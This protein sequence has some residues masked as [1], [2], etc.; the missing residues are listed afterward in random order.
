MIFG[1]N[2]V[3][4]ID[5]GQNASG[6]PAVTVGY[7]RQEA[8]VMPLVANMDDDGAVQK[9][10]RVVDTLTAGVD[11]LHPC[12]LVG[13]KG[14]AVDT[15]SVLAS[16]GA[17]FAGDGTTGRATGGLAQFFSTGVAAQALALRGGAALVA[18][19][20]AAR[21]QDAAAAAVAPALTALMGSEE[22]KEEARLVPDRIEA[23][24]VAAFD[25]FRQLAD[26]EFITRFG[27]F[28]QH[29]A[30]PTAYCDGLD[31]NACMTKL[32]ADELFRSLSASEIKAAVDAAKAG[33]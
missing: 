33:A 1:T 20:D 29:L 28:S 17:Q 12:L 27:R 4:G 10:C 18:T 24:R 21:E 16:F 7:K 15:Y 6:V 25:Y 31:K 13:R 8:V 3:F 26:P 2:T 32:N 22:V 5:A 30:L 11:T 9:P 19:G 23:A 14:D